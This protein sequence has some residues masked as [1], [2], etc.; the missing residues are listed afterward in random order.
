ML[1]QAVGRGSR[2]IPLKQLRIR[3]PV[4]LSEAEIA[5]D[6]ECWERRCGFRGRRPLGGK[7]PGPFSLPWDQDIPFPG[8]LCVRRW[9]ER[10]ITY[11]NKCCVNWPVDG[12][13][14]LRGGFLP[15]SLAS[16]PHLM[17]CFYW[18]CCSYGQRWKSRTDSYL[19]F[20]HNTP[21]SHPNS[22]KS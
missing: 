5:T 7:G 18:S 6:A 15:A 13:Q 8:M 17:M 16:R 9:G 10:K 2:K 3:G 11:A 19:N 14:G 1:Y 20:N 21:L 12:K 22:F 4:R